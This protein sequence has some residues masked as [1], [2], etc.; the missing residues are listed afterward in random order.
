MLYIYICSQLTPTDCS[1]D[2]SLRSQVLQSTGAP[3]P[4][5]RQET[6]LIYSRFLPFVSPHTSWRGKGHSH[7]VPGIL[8]PPLARRSLKAKMAMPIRC[9]ACT[10][11]LMTSRVMPRHLRT[12]PHP[13]GITLKA[14]VPDGHRR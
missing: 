13:T 7:Y 9:G 11:N 8:Y 6:E 5:D 2:G 4:R 12:P 3:M 14:Q 10:R 1:K